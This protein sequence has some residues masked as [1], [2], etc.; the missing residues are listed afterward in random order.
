VTDLT[1]P[2]DAPRRRLVRLLSD[3]ATAGAD[4][5]HLVSGQAPRA[6]VKGALV[7]LAAAPFDGPALDAIALGLFG[8][9]RLERLPRTGVVSTALRLEGGR[10][11]RASLA[12]S[13]GAP[14][15]SVRFRHAGSPPSLAEVGAPPGARALVEA[16]HG[17]ALVAGPTGSGKTTTLYALLDGLVRERAVHV[18]TVEDTVA[19]EL[20]SDRALVQQ[21]EV[22]SD[23]PDA[24]AGITAALDQDLDVLAITALTDLDALW[25][26]LHAAETGHL[27]LLQVHAAD[28]RDALDRLLEAAPGSARPIARRLV[29]DLLRGVVAQRLLPRAPTGRVPLYELLLPDEAL[30]AALR[31]GRPLDGLAGAAGSITPAAELD[32]LEAQGLV[33]AEVARDARAGLGS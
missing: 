28:A 32:R 33:T 25:A 30:R 1:D 3:A 9:A 17:L 23:V 19:F 4:H 26:A 27:V 16:T 5:V 20:A 8:A 11:A 13:L 6:R 21:R 14:T 31:E 22:G 15:L 10:T 7:P 24:A 29:A 18:C 2:I 12:T